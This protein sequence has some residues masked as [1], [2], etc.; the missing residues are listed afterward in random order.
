MLIVYI[1]FFIMVIT[2]IISGLL[3]KIIVSPRDEMLKVVYTPSTSATSSCAAPGGSG[4]PCV[5]Y[6][7]LPSS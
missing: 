1:S 4:W 6:A 2:C 7:D 5:A 3:L